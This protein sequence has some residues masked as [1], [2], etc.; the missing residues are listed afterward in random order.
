MNYYRIKPNRLSPKWTWAER[1]WGSLNYSDA[2]KETYCPLCGRE[3]L[4]AKWLGPYRFTLSSGE[5]PDFIFGA[6]DVLVSERVKRF[7]EKSHLPG[8]ESFAEC[9]VF[10]KNVPV[11]TKFYMP[12]FAFSQKKLEFAKAE[13]EKRENDKSL[14][15]C[16]LCRVGEKKN[17]NFYFDGTEEYDIF[18]IYERP[19]ELFCTQKFLDLCESNGFSGINDSVEKINDGKLAFTKEEVFEIMGKYYGNAYWREAF[20]LGYSEERLRL[21]SEILD[22]INA[23]GYNFSNL[24]RLSDNEDIRFIPIVLEYFPR[25]SMLKAFHCRSY[26]RYTPELIVLWKNPDYVR[27]RWDIGNAILACRYKKFVPQYLEIVNSDGYGEEPDLIMQTLCLLKAKEALPRLLELY[28][29]YPDVWRWDL[30]RYGWYFKDKS[31]LPYIEPYLECD[32]G[33]YRRMAKKA[34]E[35]L[36]LLE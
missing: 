17:E 10:R 13:N 2:E 21:I 33:E 27:Y 24:H 19:H 4:G 26:Y 1:E 31:I 35:K 32:D 25:I 16:S 22:K 28:E 7:Y 23:L 36:S 30:L 3:M 5:I 18:R 6:R 8:I 20:E 11:E 15:R 12:K 9:E 29:K 34:A 14:P